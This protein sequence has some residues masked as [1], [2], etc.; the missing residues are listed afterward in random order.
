[1]TQVLRLSKT[2]AER[3]LRV[4]YLTGHTLGMELA[5]RTAAQVGIVALKVFERVFPEPY[6]LIGLSE[7]ISQ[8][9]QGM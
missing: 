9:Q 6:A 7:R 5:L 1:M 2:E 4:D 8:L 3:E